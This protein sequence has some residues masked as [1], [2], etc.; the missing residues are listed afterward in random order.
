MKRPT[1]NTPLRET[2][3]V[4]IDPRLVDAIDTVADRQ[5]RTRSDIIRQ[6]VLKEL[7]AHGICAVRTVLPTTHNSLETA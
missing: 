7:E 2:V 4:R 3:A 6:G 1:K 5:F